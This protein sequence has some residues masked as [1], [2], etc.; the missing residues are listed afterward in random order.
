MTLH[1][2]SETLLIG[3][4]PVMSLA[5]LWLRLRWRTRQEHARRRSLVALVKVMPPGGQIEERRP[6][7]TLLRLAIDHAPTGQEQ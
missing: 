1:L 6:D 4:S 5:A 3:L 2:M 7:G